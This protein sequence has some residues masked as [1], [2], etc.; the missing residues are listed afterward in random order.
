MKNKSL[1]KKI[2]I[3]TN[4]DGLKNKKRQQNIWKK[5][6]NGKKKNT[7]ILRVKKVMAGKKD[8]LVKRMILLLEKFWSPREGGEGA[9]GK[10][11]AFV[12]FDPRR[13]KPADRR[14]PPRRPRDS[15]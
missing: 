15:G 12:P 5:E 7:E 10:T 13:V 3:L 8:A 2:R 6:G 14:P 4:M 11:N 1:K 9:I